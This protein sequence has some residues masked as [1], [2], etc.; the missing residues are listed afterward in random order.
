MSER[1]TAFWI[2]K[3]RLA[4]CSI[5]TLWYGSRRSTT[6]NAQREKM[7]CWNSTESAERG[8]IP[9]DCK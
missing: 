3:T 5:V 4:M 9:L 1:L 6:V 8:L 2:C 7:R